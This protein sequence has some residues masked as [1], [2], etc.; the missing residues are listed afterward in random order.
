MGYKSAWCSPQN[1]YKSISLN[2][3][4]AEATRTFFKE[5]VPNSWGIE[6]NRRVLLI[7]GCHCF[8]SN[9]ILSALI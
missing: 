9:N 1:E 5:N 6:F 3:I 8:N 2:K 4:M 7:N